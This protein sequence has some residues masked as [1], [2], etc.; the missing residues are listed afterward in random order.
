MNRDAYFVQRR[1]EISRDYASYDE[2]GFRNYPALIF[3]QPRYD[4]TV[5]TALTCKL[6]TEK[7]IIRAVRR[8]NVPA[9][10]PV[11]LIILARLA[12]PIRLSKLVSLVAIARFVAT[13]NSPVLI[14]FP[15]RKTVSM[16][17]PSDVLNVLKRKLS[18]PIRCLPCDLID[19][20]LESI[21]YAV[22]LAK[23]RIYAPYRYKGFDLET[24]D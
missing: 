22:N 6:W 9:R 13:H 16:A 10:A 5:P 14:F 1:H 2:S 21:G 11:L 24:L 19:G 15:R 23:P 7:L 12:F 20:S 4:M 3:A 18:H 8:E 17:L